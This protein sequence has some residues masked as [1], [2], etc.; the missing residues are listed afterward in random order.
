MAEYLYNKPTLNYNRYVQ[1]IIDDSICFQWISFWDE[2]PLHFLVFHDFIQ[3]YP[4]DPEC[5]N[6]KNKLMDYVGRNLIRIMETPDMG[7]RDP[8]AKMNFVQSM[9]AFLQEE[10]PEAMPDRLKRMAMN[11]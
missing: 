2:W 5:L 4:E 8:D 11:N 6:A 3:R 9:L 7:Y 1:N 10:Y